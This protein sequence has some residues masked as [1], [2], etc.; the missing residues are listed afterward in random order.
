MISPEQKRELARLKA[1]YR[2]HYMWKFCV[3]PA[4]WYQQAV[5]AYSKAGRNGSVT[6]QR[7][8]DIGCGFG[9][10]VLVCQRAGETATGL[11]VP[12]P[13]IEEAVRILGI[14]FSPYEVTA[15]KRLPLVY[16]RLDLV[17][18]FGVMFRHGKPDQS[19]DYWEWPEYAFLA[20]DI[21]GRLR[22]GGRWVIRPNRQ[23]EAGHDFSHML[24]RHQWLMA[25]GDFA[26]V[27][28]AGEQITITPRE[29]TYD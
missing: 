18:T 19:G 7:I 15:M 22:A 29:V 21:C 14:R 12:D 16:E 4:Q 26:S 9:Y 17:T 8:L 2:G 11:D 1:Q 13:L 3:S 6:R 27:A 5:Y 28:I 23:S 24:D 10:F 25:V 20:E